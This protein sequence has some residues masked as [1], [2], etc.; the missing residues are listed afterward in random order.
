[1]TLYEI[2]EQ[3]QQALD[4]AVDAETGEIYPE[5][6][7]AVEA[8]EMIRAEKIEATACYIKNRS[9][10]AAAIANEIKSL[11]ARKRAEEK[12]AEGAMSYLRYFLNGQK[13]NSP[14]VAITYRTSQSVEIDDIKNIPEEYLRY[15]DPEPDKTALK[16]AIKD[17]VN[18]P[19]VHLTNKL[20][21]QIK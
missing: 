12:R 6:Y 14:K 1:M 18:I 13:F 16:K 17:G 7:G 15:K 2:E 4:A 10:N 20:N 19:G 3:I 9:A 8:L 21:M 5:A 11:Q